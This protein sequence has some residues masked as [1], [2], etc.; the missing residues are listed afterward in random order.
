MTTDGLPE[1]PEFES[2]STERILRR[3]SEAIF[4]SADTTRQVQ[5]TAAF[6]SR[7]EFIQQQVGFADAVPDDPFAGPTPLPGDHPFD[8]GPAAGKPQDAPPP[9]RNAAPDPF[10]APPDPVP[11]AKDP[12]E[13]QPPLPGDHPFDPDLPD[14]KP[15]F[16]LLVEAPPLPNS[17]DPMV[18]DALKFQNAE[19]GG[20]DQDE[21]ANPDAPQEPQASQAPGSQEPPEFRQ[22]WRPDDFAQFTFEGGESS[23]RGGRRVPQQQFAPPVEMPE[24]P[25]QSGE[26]ETLFHE[27]DSTILQMAQQYRE[28]DRQFRKG[29]MDIFELIIMD[30]HSDNARLMS[31]ARHFQ[32]S[33]RS[34]R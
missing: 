18:A 20:D 19:A 1:R 6:A 25:L 31:I 34:T 7:Q 4:V 14:Q 5:E 11:P 2:Q 13:G 17:I 3:I 15:D 32:Q 10:A 28:A 27:D 16:S 29:V 26:Q 30:L 12:F 33:R 23:I 24:H 8:A 22:E 9:A 21:E